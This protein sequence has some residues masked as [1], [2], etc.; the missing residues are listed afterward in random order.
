VDRDDVIQRYYAKI[1]IP[2]RWHHAPEAVAIVLLSLHTNG[3]LDDSD[4]P[5]TFDERALAE[6]FGF[7]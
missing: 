6:Y 2:K 3:M 7:K 4:A 1:S 5:R